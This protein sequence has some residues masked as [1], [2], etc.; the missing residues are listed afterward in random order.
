MFQGSSW[1]WTTLVVARSIEQRLE[2]IQDHGHRI[3]EVEGVFSQSEI[4][5]IRSVST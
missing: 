1:M 3:K 2:K 5:R 4:M